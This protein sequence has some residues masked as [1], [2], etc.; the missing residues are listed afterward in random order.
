MTIE[1]PETGTWT[2]D[3]FSGPSVIVSVQVAEGHELPGE[4]VAALEALSRA[5]AADGED[6]AGYSLAGDQLSL[7]A[8]PLAMNP[9]KLGP[10]IVCGCKGGNSC[11]CKKNNSVVSDFESVEF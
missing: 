10:I 2:E 7:T 3:D 6:V 4:A 5:L 11:T 9:F 1:V 8:D